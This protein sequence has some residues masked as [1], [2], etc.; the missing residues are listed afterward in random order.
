MLDQPGRSV[1]CGRR[2]TALNCNPN[3]NLLNRSG[4]GVKPDGYARCPGQ[5]DDTGAAGTAAPDECG[6]AIGAECD[7]LGVPAV[8]GSSPVAA[9]VRR[10][11]LGPVAGTAGQAPSPVLVALRSRPSLDAG[12]EAYHNLSAVW[13]GAFAASAV[14][15]DQVVIVKPVAGLRT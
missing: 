15:R 14:I 5:P 3:C 6:T 9:P 2:R 10:V 1:F 4:P 11:R 7:H 12:P 13:W 8:S